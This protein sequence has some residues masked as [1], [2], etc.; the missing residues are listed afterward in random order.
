MKQTLVSVFLLLVVVSCAKSSSTNNAGPN[1]SYPLQGVYKINS[2]AANG[3]SETPISNPSYNV[4][5]NVYSNTE[6]NI[7]EVIDNS[8]IYFTQVLLEDAGSSKYT[9]YQKN[10]N[11]TIQGYFLNGYLE[12]TLTSGATYKVVKAHL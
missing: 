10:G 3:A 7:N 6:V 2:I 12:Y 8:S 9:F 11:L 5:V 4:L 1:L